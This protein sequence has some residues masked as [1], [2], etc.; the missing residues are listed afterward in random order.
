MSRYEVLVVEDE[1]LLALE[2]ADILASCA[3]CEVLTSTT[4]EQA[5]KAI[6]RPLV[7][8]VL[9]IQVIGGRTFELAETLRQRGVP[10]LFLSGRA[11][12]EIPASLKEAPYLEKP[13]AQQDL[14]KAFFSAL[15]Q[16]K[17]R[18]AATVA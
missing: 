11:A 4:I 9:D 10:L 15:K 2:I 1:T 8:A 7:F 16:V 5:R 3:S 12:T 18:Q 13:F 6:E 14:K 17:D